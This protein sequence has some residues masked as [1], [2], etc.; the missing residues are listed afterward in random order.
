MI[1]MVE[2]PSLSWTILECTPWASIRLGHSNIA[3]TM[4]IYSHVLP[5]LQEAAA[6]ALDE[7]LANRKPAAMN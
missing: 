2:C 5:G 3:I 7:C 1:A 6:L 4:D